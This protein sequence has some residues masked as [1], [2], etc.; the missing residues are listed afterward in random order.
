MAVGRPVVAF[1]LPEHRFTA[2]DA[3]LYVRPND[4]LE[5]ARAIAL[6]MNDPALRRRMGTSGRERIETV[7]SWPHSVPS[8]LATYCALW[9]GEPSPADLALDRAAQRDPS[10]Q[11]VA[12]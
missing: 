1:D 9:P 8:L 5:M 10:E 7:L 11:T 4:E 12:V 6:L 2:Q 3:A